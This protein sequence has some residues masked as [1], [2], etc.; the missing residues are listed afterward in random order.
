[1]RLLLKGVATQFIPPPFFIYYP[2]HK[3]PTLAIVHDRQTRY[4]DSVNIPSCRISAGQRAFYCRGVKIWN[5]L[6]KDFR[7]FINTK[8]F[9]RR[10]INELICNMK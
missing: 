6:S 5:N 7:D 9:E 4:R 8:V 1:M 2:I 10:L 3:F